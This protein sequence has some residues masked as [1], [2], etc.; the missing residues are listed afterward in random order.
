ME[1]NKKKTALVLSGGSVKGSMQYGILK[2]LYEQGFTPDVVYGTSVGNLNGMGYS[3][4]GIKGLEKFWS[5]ITKRSSLFKFNWLSLI[6]KSKGVFNTKPLR[7]LVQ[8]AIKEGIYPKI[9]CYSCC[10]NI[11]T[12]EIV[13]GTP[14]MP[15]YEDYVVASASI[16]CFNDPIGDLVDGGVREQTP[17]KKAIED[18][19]EKIVVILC[20]PYKQNPDEGKNGNWIE[21]LLRTTDLMAHEIFIN[22]IEAC[23]WY[24]ANLEPGKRK[25]E[26]EVYCPEKLVIDSMDFTQDKIQPAIL[27]GYECAKKGPIIKE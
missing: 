24:N 20:N 27:Y 5:K 12:G 9:P 19:C 11:K 3:Y 22:D 17:L 7:K 13:Y 8:E 23:R 4:I 18:G 15:D 25:I 16:P 1:I 6:L 2:Y 26:L 14:D 10:V 21:N